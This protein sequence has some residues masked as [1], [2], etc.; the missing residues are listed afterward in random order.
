VYDRTDRPEIKFIS[1]C[2]QQNNSYDCGIYL[3]LFANFL[4]VTLLTKDAMR[5]G[6]DDT[7]WNN[8]VARLDVSVTEEHATSFRKRIYTEITSSIKTSVS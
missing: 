3:L 7:S 4:A 6:F 2:P 8:I 5:Q 1:E